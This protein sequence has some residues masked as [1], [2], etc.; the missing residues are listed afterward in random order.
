MGITYPASVDAFP[1]PAL[2]EVT[3]LSSPGTANRAHTDHHRDLGLGLVA[4]MTHAALKT[5]AHLGGADGTAKLPQIATHEAVDTDVSALALHHTLGKGEFQ[6]AHGNHV[7]DYYGTEILNAP[8]K[9]CTSSSRP[10]NPHLGLM[11]YETDTNRVRVWSQFD[12]NVTITGFDYTD[13]FER[14]VANDLGADYEI[15]YVSGTSP[16]NGTM[17]IA[18][19]HE[20]KWK[21][22]GNAGM[23]AIARNINP[24]NMHTE[25]T[26]QAFTWTTGDTLIEEAIWFTWPSFNDVYLRMSDDKQ[27]YL[28]FKY[29]VRQIEAYYSKTG[30]SGE[31]RLGEIKSRNA[32]RNMPMQIV[33]NDYSFEFYQMGGY[34][35][36]IIDVNEESANDPAVNL[37]WALGMQTGYRVGGQTSPASVDSVRIQDVSRLATSPRWTL[38]PAASIPYC[39]LRQTV[40][41][42]INPTGSFLEWGANGSATI[43][44]DNFGYYDA[45]LSLTELFIREPGLY[46]IDTA[47]QWNPSVVGDNAQVVLCLNGIET[48]IRNHQWMRGNGFNPNFSQSVAV[49]GKLRFAAN[50]RLSVKVKYNSG[51]GLNAWFSSF[52]DNNSRIMSRI[53][54]SFDG[55]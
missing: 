35:G 40:A 13:N 54:V 10:A 44:E 28:R 9:L 6:A 49:S 8:F 24:T 34:L 48:S 12:N 23:R 5:H 50:D 1:V 33:L 29:G 25:T 15:T 21:D 17:A 37:G 27:E 32:I 46:H 11:I 43:I 4:V 53:D 19:G 31:V 38:L 2:P 30:F 26:N 55:V 45:N 18:N 42:R 14:T 20:V 52:L 36:T 39:R 41:Q 22:A 47:I 51:S 3:S 7:H 16:A